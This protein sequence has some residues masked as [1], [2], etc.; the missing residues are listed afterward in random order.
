MVIVVCSQV[1]NEGEKDAGWECKS[2]GAEGMHASK[3]KLLG[4][5]E[6]REAGKEE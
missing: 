5:L 3:G 6:V 1:F 4:K 2:E